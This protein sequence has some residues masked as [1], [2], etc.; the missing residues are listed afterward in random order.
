MRRHGAARTQFLAAVS[1]LFVFVVV[2]VA[3][4]GT[5]APLDLK[6]KKGPKAADKLVTHYGG[7]HGPWIES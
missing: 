7:W 3:L 4:A 1:A 6:K 2:Q 5:S